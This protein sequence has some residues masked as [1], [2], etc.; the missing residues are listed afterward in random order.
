MKVDAPLNWMSPKVKSILNP[1]QDLPAPTRHRI[2]STSERRADEHGT[3]H[4][5]CAKRT[6]IAVAFKKVDLPPIFG[7]VKLM[8]RQSL[9]KMLIIKLI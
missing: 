5:I 8:K 6:V 3:K 9:S 2:E 4:P 7:P 1:N